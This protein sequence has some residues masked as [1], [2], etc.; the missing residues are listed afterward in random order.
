M[1]G[2]KQAMAT[3]AVRDL[4]SASAFYETTLGLR[5][6][7]TEG[8]EAITYEA[9]GSRLLV[10][11]SSHAGTNQ[12]TAVTWIVGEDVT[13]AAQALRAKGVAFEHYDM[14]GMRLEGDVHVAEGMRV[15]WFR[16]PDGNIHALVS[17]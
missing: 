2:S 7:A 6:I 16:D 8:S 13:G 9:G 10:Y 1:L 3:V 14:P 15:A 17:G 4:A 12:A 5:R 11:R